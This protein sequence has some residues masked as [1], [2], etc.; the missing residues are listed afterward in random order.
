M[1]LSG[2]KQTEIVFKN[3]LLH[4]LS[5]TALS[6]LYYWLHSAPNFHPSTAYIGDKLGKDKRNVSKAFTELTKK[7]VLRIVGRTKEGRGIYEIYPE[8]LLD[9]SNG[10]QAYGIHTDT[11]TRISQ[12]TTGVSR[13]ATTGGIS[14]YTQPIEQPQKQPSQ[15][16]PIDGTTDQKLRTVPQR[17]Y[18]V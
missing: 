7:Y 10:T 12:D 1:K 8:L 16:G 15:Q 6:V 13:S 5:V 17:K 9:R 2:H 18:H 11:Q 14:R 3:A 4:N